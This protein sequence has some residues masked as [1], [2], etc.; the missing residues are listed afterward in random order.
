M[1]QNVLH[2]NS[3]LDWAALQSHLQRNSA[4]ADISVKKRNQSLCVC[5]LDNSGHH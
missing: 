3:L 5:E 2:K 1:F 4:S